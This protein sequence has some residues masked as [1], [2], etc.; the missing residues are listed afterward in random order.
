LNAECGKQGKVLDYLMKRT[1]LM[2]LL[3]FFGF[4]NQAFCQDISIKQSVKNANTAWESIFPGKRCVLLH[5]RNQ[6]YETTVN[7]M[8]SLK[9]DVIKTNSRINPYKLTVRIEIENWSSKEKKTS[10]RD[11]LANVDKKEE[12]FQKSGRAKFPLTGVYELEDG[13][14]VYSIGNKWM[15]NFIKRARAK[16]NTHVN[17]SKILSIPEK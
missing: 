9:C 16:Y 11:A 13:K 12:G 5:K 10:I 15:I 7:E 4:Y 6:K 2:T 17:I 14:W 8:K 1:I 3:I